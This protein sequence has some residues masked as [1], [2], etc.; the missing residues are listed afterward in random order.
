VESVAAGLATFDY[1]GDG[2]IDLYFL[3]GAPLPG[4]P[5]GPAPRNALYRNDGGWKFTDVT[6]AAGVGDTGY[7]LGVCVGD[8]NNDGHPDLYLNNF[9]PN[10]L[11]RNNGN[12]TFTDVTGPAGVKNGDRVGAGAAFL[13]IDH[14]GDLDLFVAN[15]IDFTPAKHRTRVVNGHPAYVG[16]HDVRS[17]SFEPVPQQRRRDVHRRQPGVRYRDAGRNGNGCGLRRL[18]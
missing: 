4:A 18:R 14:D 13:D 1:D 8:Y 16:P 5:A 12:G 11:Y 7:G 15:Y 17:H 6:Q 9:G 10:V 2:D 3:N